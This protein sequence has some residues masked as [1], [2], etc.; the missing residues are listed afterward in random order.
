MDAILDQSGQILE[1]Q[2][3]DL[4]RTDT[5]LR[6][7][8]RSLSSTLQHWDSPVPE[9]SDNE[10]TPDSDDDEGSESEESDRE[11]VA[12]GE[13][14]SSMLLA[15]PA[16]PENGIINGFEYRDSP[17]AMTVTGETS[18]RASTPS[19]VAPVSLL[20]KFL[21]KDD[22]DEIVEHDGALYK[23]RIDPHGTEIILLDDPVLPYRNGHISISGPQK[24]VADASS[25]GRSSPAQT[26]R[27]D[28]D[29]EEPAVTDEPPQTPSEAYDTLPPE[30]SHGDKK[31]RHIS[32]VDEPEIVFSDSLAVDPYKALRIDTKFESTIPAQSSVTLNGSPPDEEAKL[33]QAQAPIVHDEETEQLDEV[34]AEADDEA[35]EDSNIPMYLRPYAVAPVEWDPQAKVKPPLLLRGTLRPYQQAGMEWLASLHCSNLNGILADEMGLGFVLPI[36]H[37]VQH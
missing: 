20:D 17:P 32:F 25:P 21:T 15:E 1:A 6:S 24:S 2:H 3:V 37:L 5:G 4:S 22:E 11:S 35:E 31:E 10:G 8:S 23:R 34:N 18:S 28:E 26:P 7:R 12:G 19:S 27:Y 36:Y 13:M 14:D 29:E 33:L 9:E 16:T 30:S